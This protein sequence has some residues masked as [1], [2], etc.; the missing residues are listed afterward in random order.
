MR[1][2]NFAEI[3]QRSIT[4]R[5]FHAYDFLQEYIAEFMTEGLS[6][7]KQG[8]IKTSEQRY[9]GMEKAEEALL[10]VHTGANFGKAV[11]IVSDDA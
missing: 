9:V 5:G 1:R 3:F 2:Q 4:V 11:V 10:A 8:K 6:L 7:I